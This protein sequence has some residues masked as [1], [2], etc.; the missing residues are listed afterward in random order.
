M[1]QTITENQFVSAFA[2]YNRHENF[3]VDGRIALY[4][5]ITQLDEECGT[6]TELDV[7]ALCC[8]FSEWENI[9][10]FQQ[11][12]GEEYQSF[13]DINEATLLIDID[14]DRFITQDF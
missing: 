9:E 7:I 14:G 4:E 6:E 1:K 3:S 11:N 2:D 8:E 12:Y 5:F 10:E 13:D